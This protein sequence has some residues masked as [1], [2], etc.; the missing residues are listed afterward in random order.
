MVN[1][2]LA[3]DPYKNMLGAQAGGLTFLPLRITTLSISKA[4]ASMPSK[5]SMGFVAVQSKSSGVN[6]K[7][8]ENF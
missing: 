4:T 7:W 6:P 2:L 3:G 8:L 5:K 1:K